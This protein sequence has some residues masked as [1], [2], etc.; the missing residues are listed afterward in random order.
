MKD[1]KHKIWNK[2]ITR[3]KMLKTMATAAGT[4][5]GAGAFSGFPMVWAQKLKDVK[6][7]HVGSPYSIPAEIAKQATKDLGFEIESQA[8]ASDVLQTRVLTQAKTVDIADL[9]YVVWPRVIPRG[10]CQGIEISKIKEWNNMVPIFTQGKNADGSPS[11][12]EGSAPYKLMYLEKPD[13]RKTVKKQ[14]DYAL[15]VPTIYNA[16]T[17]GI[18][19][20]LINRPIEKWSELFNPEFRGKAGLIDYPGVGI[21]DSAM[22]IESMGK[23][24]YADKGNMT[25]EEIDLTVGYL[26]K[27]KAQ[28]HWRAFWTHFDE[29]VNLMASGEVIIQSMWSPAVTAVRARGIPCVYQPL[30]EGYRAW[31]N[32]LGI[33]K[34]L[35][36][37]KLEAAYEYLN[38]Y[39][40]GW[41]GGF[42]ARQGYYSAVPSTAKKFL[43][44]DEWNYWYE[45]KP[46][47][48]DIL[49]PYGKAQEKAGHVRDG[50]SFWE[51]MG[52]IACWNAVM[53][54]DRYLTKKW[55]EFVAS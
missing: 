21:M 47:Q 42:I 18:R 20:D 31:G 45:G 23:H 10:V 15:S 3:R 53:K 52:K 5:I 43:T 24:K 36:G 30:K 26:K 51:R 22:A 11:S 25:R 46:A 27:L 1:K 14:T 32:S 49:D 9:S 34:H 13:A 54:E 12:M 7:L 50:G 39:L 17:L 35:S 28:G 44:S 38:W 8:L 37:L 6:L 29:S 16:D 55:N 4:A 40:S 33:M 48:N 41:Y 2:G 19:P